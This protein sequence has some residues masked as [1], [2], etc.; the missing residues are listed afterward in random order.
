MALKDTVSIYNMK[1]KTIKLSLK[2]LNPNICLYISINIL[3][4]NFPGD[5]LL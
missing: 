4:H 3:S 5:N 2:K 1:S